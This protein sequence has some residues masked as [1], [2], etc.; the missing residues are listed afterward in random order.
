MRPLLG[1]FLGHVSDD[2]ATAWVRL[3]RHAPLQ[4][5]EAASRPLTGPRAGDPAAERVAA[6]R[7]VTP[8]DGTACGVVPLGGGPAEMHRIEVRMRA[9]GARPQAPLGELV[10]HAA[11]RPASEGRIAFAFGSC[12]K[13]D[14]LGDA[15]ATWRDILALARARHVDHLLLVGDQIYADETPVLTS[16]AG[17]TAV[18]RAMRLGPGAPLDRRASGWREEY[19]RAWESSEVRSV[20]QSLPVTSIWDDHEIVNGF[21]TAGWHREEKGRSIFEAAAAA[22]DEFQGCR[23]PPRLDPASRAHAFRR[24]PA[25]FLTL[26][27]R[28]HR[29]AEQRVLLGGRQKEAIADW[30]GTAWA[31]DARVLFVVASVPV[32]HLSRLFHRL[33][34]RWDLE[35]Q[36]SS[37]SNEEDRA[38]LLARLLDYAEG[39]RRRVVILGGDSHLATVARADGATARADGAT[40]LASGRGPAL[41]QLT[42]SPLANRLPAIVY[43]ALTLFGR[44]FRMRVGASREP[45]Q[46]LKAHVI[47]RRQGA[48]VGVVTGEATEEGVD[49]AFELFRPGRRTL[50][51]RLE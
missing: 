21:G 32:M 17:R 39:G 40:A 41:W 27:L 11:P 46:E 9:E 42:S 25:A 7:P 50:G 47:A 13:C 34:G 5:V 4:L 3:P 31:R 6:L 19:Q 35:D 2:T 43:P 12:W 16:L 8:G 51:I 14:A 37:A 1:P 36:W 22:Y 48:N 20:L 49:L 29:H 33:R 24:G 28:T 23:N 44:R 15:T 26:D 18:K 30:L 10:V 45:E 38:W